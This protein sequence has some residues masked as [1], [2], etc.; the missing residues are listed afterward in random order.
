MIPQPVRLRFRVDNIRQFI[1]LRITSGLITVNPDS[2]AISIAKISGDATGVIAGTDQLLR[3]RVS[4]N[5][6]NVIAGD[7]IRFIIRSGGGTISGSDSIGVITDGAGNAEATLTTGLTAGTNIVTAL[8]IDDRADSVQFSVVTVS[9]GVSYYTLTPA[10]GQ[11]IVA[12]DSV[13]YILKAFD[14]FGNAV[15]NGDSVTLTTPGSAT[16]GFSPGPYEFGGTDSLTFR[17]SD[18]TAGSFTVRADNIDNSAITI[19]SGLITVLPG[20]VT[21]ILMLS[22]S[23]SINVGGERLLQY[24]LEDVYGNRLS[25]SLMIFS[26]LRGNGTFDNGLDTTN[27]RTNASGIAQAN[28]TASDVLSFGSDSIEI[29]YGGLNAVLVL[30][31]RSS[32][33]SYYTLSPSA[34]STLT[35]GDSLAYTVTARDQFGNAIGNDGGLNLI[36]QGSSTA[37]FSPAPYNFNG[38]DT[39]T[40][41]VSDS[42]AGSFTVRV[43]NTG[44]SSISG[45]SG[46]ITVNPDSGTISI[47]KISGDATGVI[48]G[49]DQL[50]RVRVSDNFANV[51]AGD[52]IRFIIRSGGGTISGSDSIGVITDGAG[53]AEATLTTGLTAGT[54][55]VTA[56][57]ISD[58]ADSVQFSVVTVSGGLTEIRIQRIR[59]ADQAVYEDS[60]ITTDST[61]I[62]FA[63]GYDANGVYLGE[64]ISDWT[65][66]GEI[67]SFTTTSP[68]DSII[69]DPTTVGSGTIRAADTTNALI[70]DQSGLITV[71]PGV[72]VAITIRNAPDGG[73]SVAGTVYDH[74]WQFTY[75]LRRRI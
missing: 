1:D 28:Y 63:S 26:R 24:A 62:L 68:N 11:T 75:F 22:S 65:V 57:R 30:P 32:L 46:L 21:S 19:T 59:G 2:G 74:G 8:R 29:N 25:D 33:V 43:E 73:G 14:Q 72:M 52:S 51:I 31:L 66:S 49:T 27:V 37:G 58:R 60:I 40:F 18:S 34:D 38:A 44:S 61:L 48:A 39:L 6:A 35:V 54:N 4:D 45:S 53:N 10:T 12:G 55:I 9:G 7:S 15:A 16:A 42:T 47:A 56:L 50:L 13:A 64:V 67:G 36:R 23:D 69:F 17:V 71:N 70:N 20:D 41:R 3:V 5:F